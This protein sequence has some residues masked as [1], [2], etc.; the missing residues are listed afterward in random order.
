MPGLNTTGKPNTDDYYLGRG[1]LFAAELD[2]N[3]HPKGY[4]DLGNATEFNLT[5]ESETLEHQSSRRGLRVTDKEVVTSQKVTATFA[6]DELNFQNLAEF[7]S[8]ETDAFNN[9]AAVAGVTP[10]GGTGNLTVFEQGQHYDLYGLVGGLPAADSHSNRIYDIGAVTIVPE[11]G[12]AAFVLG[13]DY[14]IDATWGTIFI[15]PGGG[16][17]GSVNGVNYEVTIAAN[18]SADPSVDEVKALTQT[19]RTVALKFIS[20][21]PA[22][23]DRQAEVQLHQVNLKA[24]GDLNMIGEEF[25]TMNFTGVAEANETADAD[26]PT[27]TIRYVDQ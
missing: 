2:A 1:C 5:V 23:N 7:F 19:S 9:A 27:M 22:D 8:G 18:P 12:G 3:G 4:R 26:S 11:G 17:A 15:V 14:E 24:E 20:E 10:V 6:L 25:S 13:T 21:N 16:M